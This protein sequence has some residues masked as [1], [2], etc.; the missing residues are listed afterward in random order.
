M[1]N[2]NPG[3]SFHTPE[4]RT[5]LFPARSGTPFA[6]WLVGLAAIILNFF[7]VSVSWGVS[8]G[9]M[10][11]KSHLG[12]PFQGMVA[13]TLGEKEQ[14][15]PLEVTTAHPDDYQPLNLDYNEQVGS[16]I[17]KMEGKGSRRLLSVTTKDPVNIPFFNL[18]L[19]LSL[20]QGDHFRNYPV[21]LEVRPTPLSREFQPD[22]KVNRPP[23]PSPTA[24]EPGEY[25]PVRPGETLIGIAEKFTPPHLTRHQVLAAFFEHNKSLLVNGNMNGLPVGTVLR[26]P[27]ADDQGKLN[28]DQAKALA[29][30]HRQTWLQGQKN[31]NAAQDNRSRSEPP[32]SEKI[33]V[34][35][36]TK[37]TGH[38]MPAHSPPTQVEPTAKTRETPTPHPTTQSA[39]EPVATVVDMR[40]TLSPSG[41]E[42]ALA[43]TN[44]LDTAKDPVS[45]QPEPVP[46]PTVGTEGV[47]AVALEA[48][49]K[50]IAALSE[51]LKQSESARTTLQQQL[52]ALEGRFRK[53]EQNRPPPVPSS[54]P[55]ME[56]PW[57]LAGSVAAVVVILTGLLSW[58]RL[59]SKG[60]GNSDPAPRPQAPPVP[61][62][63]ERH[64]TD[65][66]ANS[67]MPM[68]RDR[69]SSH[70]PPSSGFPLEALMESRQ[71][72]EPSAVLPDSGHDLAAADPR[73]RESAAIPPG[74]PFTPSPPA[75]QEIQEPRKEAM[76]A[77][78]RSSFVPLA[79]GTA[80]AIAV[81]SS[82]MGAREEDGIHEN[83]LDLGDADDESDSIFNLAGNTGKT[84][85][86]TVGVETLLGSARIDADLAIG[87]TPPLDG[88]VPGTDRVAPLME[89]SPANPFALPEGDALVKPLHAP[90]ESALETLTFAL[91]MPPPPEASAVEAETVSPP[92]G[93]A[94]TD[95]ESLT[96]EVPAIA[97]T[98]TD[99]PVAKS[100]V[101]EIETI[102]FEPE[103]TSRK[104]AVVVPPPTQD[105]ETEK[106]GRP[107]A[108]IAMPQTRDDNDTFDLSDLELTLDGDS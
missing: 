42:D 14:G 77:A 51:Q 11:V 1:K 33:E 75:T 89:P 106:K 2:S 20:G 7:L 9:G 86:D 26:V 31:G 40:L 101:I 107:G 5:I 49:E 19:K 108:I 13:V 8:L 78:S 87:S 58:R 65:L 76:S 48:L 41:K 36:V 102:P 99:V 45:R 73:T 93:N 60:K 90:G 98:I 47:T 18:L 27:P 92:P 55:E 66:A 68:H 100:P 59:R 38:D 23:S 28:P 83:L 63:R 53:L 69:L 71:E 17:L 46:A 32:A 81:T 105:N 85:L 61:P 80:G 70:R 54:P 37:G 96:F 74:T 25:G 52:T 6:S 16:V 15:I 22:R 79:L 62:S 44:R 104:P 50:E 82:L 103:E 91:A 29:A 64:M 12:E 84:E 43:L 57:E 94:M 95:I 30:S 88:Q 3:I 4:E 24:I 72:S 67:V 56:I 97:E 34:Q 21:F 35:P 10:E 39:N